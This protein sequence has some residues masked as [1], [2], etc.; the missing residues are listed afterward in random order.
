[1]SNKTPSYIRHS[2][3]QPQVSVPNNSYSPYAQRSQYQMNSFSQMSPFSQ[4]YAEQDNR[5]LNTRN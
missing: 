2:Q 3:I 5:N 1:M 4:E